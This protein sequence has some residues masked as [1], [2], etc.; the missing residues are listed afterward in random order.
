M[1]RPKLT[2]LETTKYLNFALEYS[3]FFW[4]KLVK[5]EI[6]FQNYAAASDF[7]NAIMTCKVKKTKNCLK[8]KQRWAKRN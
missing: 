6:F 7:K 2:F 3:V 1:L 8:K 5:F 4:L